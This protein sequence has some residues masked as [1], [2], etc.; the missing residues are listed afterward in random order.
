ML[1]RNFTL[2]IIILVIIIAVLFGWFYF[3]PPSTNGGG[4]ESNFTNFLSDFLPFGG[5][6]NNTNT[7]TGNTNTGGTDISGYED[8]TDDSFGEIKLKKVSTFP[9]SGFGVFMKERFEAIAPQDDPVSGTPTPPK[10]ELDPFVRYVEKSTGNTYQTFA[11]DIEER[12]FSSAIIPTVYEAF[13]G[14]GGESVIVR[15]LKDN[16][17]NIETFWGKL[18]KEYLGGDTSSSNGFT[19]S[20]LPENI[21]DMS[22]S[23]DKSKVFYLTNTSTGSIGTTLMLETGTRS[24]VFD[25]SLS[26]WLSSWPSDNKITLTT[27]PSYNTAGFMYVVNPNTKSFEKVLSGVNGLTTLMSPDGKKILYS[28]N[29]LSLYVYELETGKSTLL[30]VK[31]LAEKCVWDDVSELVY[32]AVPQSVNGIEYPDS[33]YQGTQSFSD[34]IWKVNTTTG[35]TYRIASPINLVGVDIDI[36][37]PELDQNG[38]YLFFLNKK[39]SYLWE[40]NLK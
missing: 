6:S 18:P 32:C 10:T 20:F 25:S 13:L 5:N 9:V 23:Q 19:G 11:D 26:E 3:F 34:E 29:N 36:I 40:F 30:G 2:L 35:I 7:D 12:Q 24:Q 27:K 21:T 22:V 1:K 15:Y 38:D 4:K 8:Q 31:T 37:K 17:N 28:N 33:W 39:D 16:S 14:N